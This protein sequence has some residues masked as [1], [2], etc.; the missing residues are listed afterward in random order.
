MESSKPEL[1]LSPLENVILKAKQFEMGPP[2]VLL[3][4]AMDPP[5]LL[6]VATTI[7]VL[8]EIGALSATHGME[9]S[10]IDGN[11][12]FMGHIMA[13]LPIDV[14][15]SR[16]IALG[17]CFSV[18]EESIIMGKINNNKRLFNS[19]NFNLKT[20]FRFSCHS[21]IEKHFQ[22]YFR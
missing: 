17:Y 6:N 10:N 9:N 3:G 22:N 1:L 2:H 14:N 16:L 21:Y 11:M 18:L 5:K 4:L 20:H 7:L 19:F 8:K 13:A 15:A 12:T